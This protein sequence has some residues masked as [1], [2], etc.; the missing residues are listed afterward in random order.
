MCLTVHGE[1]LTGDGK[2]Y[3]LAEDGRNISRH[4][5]SLHIFVELASVIK[6]GREWYLEY[7]IL[8]FNQKDTRGT[9]GHD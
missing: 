9:L 1:S 7:L 2:L 3:N 6:S 4:A 8:F 5:Q